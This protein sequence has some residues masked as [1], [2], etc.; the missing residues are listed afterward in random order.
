[1]R[2]GKEPDGGWH[3]SRR[4]F[5]SKERVGQE[6]V[7]VRTVEHELVGVFTAEALVVMPVIP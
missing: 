6:S 1:M 3:A 2:M 7:V 4:N 5:T